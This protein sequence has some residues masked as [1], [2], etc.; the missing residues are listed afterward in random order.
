[1]NEDHWNEETGW[2]DLWPVY[3]A[4]NEDVAIHVRALLESAGI[5][6]RIRSAQIPGFNGAFASAVGFWGQ[7]LVARGD[8]L[9]AR[10]VLEALARTEGGVR[11]EEGGGERGGAAE[12]P[13][14]G[15]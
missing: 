6:A 13:G 9:R 14:T 1:M 11:P 12:G 7:V 5:E 3:E 2:A 4:A 10:E 15:P 8:V